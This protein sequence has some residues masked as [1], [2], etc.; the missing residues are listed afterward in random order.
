MGLS[1]KIKDVEIDGASVCGGL[2]SSWFDWVANRSVTSHPLHFCLF[3]SIDVDDHILCESETI[4]YGR[5][6]LGNH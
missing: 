3:S 5:E 1:A 2:Q 6:Y 4:R